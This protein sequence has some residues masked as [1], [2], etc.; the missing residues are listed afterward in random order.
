M[1]GAVID[2]AGGFDDEAGCGHDDFEGRGD[3]CAVGGLF[4]ADG[5]RRFSFFDDDGDGIAV[6]FAIECGVEAVGE[7]EAERV[8]A[9][10]KVEGN[11]GLALAV[12]EV[13]RAVGDHFPCRREVG[14]DEDVEVAGAVVDFA[15]GFDDEA[16]CGHD[17]FEGRGDGR[18]VEWFEEC[19][20]LLRRVFFDKDHDGV[21]ILFTFESGM[22]SVGELES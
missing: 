1:A 6:L 10:F 21:S 16:G 9:G 4:E 5:R 18:S 14:V 13:L 3:G 22:Q 17:D 19:H 11:G 20:G 2:F 15:G 8:L 7:L 12:V